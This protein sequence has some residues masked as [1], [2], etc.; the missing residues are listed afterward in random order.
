MTSSNEHSY[1]VLIRKLIKQYTLE[2]AGSHGVWGLDDHS[3][4]PYILGSAQL[5]APLPAQSDA[6]QYP[7]MP[8][9]GSLSHAPSP[10]SITS[11][12]TVEVEAENNM[13]FAA[14][15]FI[16]D[17]KRGPF[18]EHSPY[19][20]NISGIKDGWGKINKG[21][22][23]MYDAEVLGK[24]PVVQHFP[25]GTFW[26]WEKDPTAPDRSTISVHSQQ[27]PVSSMQSQSTKAPWATQ[28]PAL[29]QPR[30]KAVHDRR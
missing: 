25:F 2:P 22:L 30:S 28:T 18:F 6:L 27:Q 26:R 14:V 21:M 3:F 5:T 13:Y 9:E 7:P 8:V 24:F 10:A 23:K 29:G 20:Y 4:I 12:R 16:L 11:A 1:L 19:L 17:V 15:A